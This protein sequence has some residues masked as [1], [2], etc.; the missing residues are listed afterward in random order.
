MDHLS[1]VHDHAKKIGDKL[2]QRHLKLVTCESC[3][4]GQLAQTI[5]SIPGASAWF[6][7]GWVT[8]SLLSK[9]QLL[10]IDP[11]LLKQYGPVSEETV[12]AMAKAALAKSAAQLSIAIT[13]IAGPEGGTKKNPVG[14]LWMAWVGNTLS[15][16]HC[17]HYSGERLI[18]RYNAVEFA[19]KTLLNLL[20]EGVGF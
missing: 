8:Y 20:N 4:G 11:A 5:T 19:L 2:Q 13:G 3:T 9:Q 7:C 6:E 16:T 1:H 15:K 14:T 10:G 17:Q 18:I 12:L